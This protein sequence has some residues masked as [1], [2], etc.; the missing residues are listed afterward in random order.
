MRISEIKEKVFAFLNKKKNIRIQGISGT[1]LSY[2]Y[3]E[4]LKD[5]NKTNLIILPNKKEA[6]KVLK[7]FLFFV[8]NKNIYEFAPYDISPFSGLSPHKE[9]I[10]KRMGSLYALLNEKAPIIVTSIDAI[11]LKT[12][13]KKDFV[14]FIDYVEEGEELDR[15]LF[16]KKLEEGGYQRVP[17]VEDIGD[18]AVRGS[19]IDIFPPLYQNPIRLEFWGDLVESI[20]QF[21]P[22]TQRSLSNKK[23]AIILPCSEIILN[24]R[25]LKRA[26]SLGRLPFSDETNPQFSGKEAW[27][28]H[29]YEKPSSIFEYLPKDAVITIYSYHSVRSVSQRIKE[30]FLKDTERFKKEAAERGDPFP[31]V[32]GLTLK[33]EELMYNISNFQTIQLESSGPFDEKTETVDV[34]GYFELTEDIE[35]RIPEKG[36]VSLAPLAEK[37]EEWKEH[38][39]RVVIVTRTKEQAE[40]LKEILKNY[41]VTV[42]R[43]LNSWKEVP[44]N[45]SGIFICLGNIANGFVWQEIGLYVISEDQIFGKKKET[46]KKTSVKLARWA[47][48]GQFKEGDL[49]VHEEHGIG[50]Y[51]GLK[52]IEVNNKINEYA[53]IEYAENSKL[54]IPADR[55]SILQKYIGVEGKEPK[56]DQLGGRSWDIAKR[57]AKNS[58]KKIAKHLVE[59]Y[60]I[61]QTRKG[62]AFSPP[63]HMFREF[64]ATF[65]HEETPDQIKAIED[66]LN[67]MTSEKPMDRLICGDVGFGKTEVAIRAAF[68]AVMDGKQVAII[69]PTTL[70]AEQHYRTFKN[71]MSPYH[72]RVEILSRFRSKTEQAKIIAELRSG[73]IDIIIGTHRLLQKDIK[74]SD[75]GLLIIDEEQKFGVK[76]KELLKK[77]RTTVDVLSLAATPIPRTL[78]MALLGVKDISIIETPPQDRLSIRTHISYYDENLIAKAIRFELKRKGQVFFVHNRVQTI[79][80]VAEKIKKLVPE[81]KLAVAHGQMKESELEKTMLS[82][83]NKEI[84]VLVCTSI[85]ESGLDIPSVNTIIID[86]VEK[87]GLAQIY[88]LRGRVGR[89]KE[90]AYAYLLISDP[91]SITPEGEK[92]LKALM[93]FSRLGAGLQLAM[94]DLKIR[95]G[96]NILGYAQSGHIAEI[97]YELYVKLIEQTIA[98]LKGEEWHEDINPEI[99]ISIPAYI[100][101]TY[102]M[103][104][105]LRLNIYR[106]LSMLS[107]ESELLK[108][109]EELLDRFGDMPEEV[110]NLFD[111]MSIRIILKKAKIS[112]LD[113]NTDG[114]TLTFGNNGY[115]DTE[116]IVKLVTQK[117]ALFK[118]ISQNKIKINTKNLSLTNNLSK[119]RS[120]LKD[121]ASFITPVSV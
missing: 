28:T 101:E 64:E 121:I 3:S 85:I 68:K 108:V 112:K 105:D 81:A 94:H 43:L 69:V 53:I 99:N 86:G 48:I 100:P 89:S 46:K 29:F 87:M 78:H 18:Y 117:P 19:V 72:I 37:V 115:I 6:N 35:I 62:F 83:L 71:R 36:R 32:E 119:I 4:L 47:D 39:G 30:K 7:E 41:S 88:Q 13:P 118:F 56:L 50:R 61:R 54:Y 9:I 24:E 102:I 17:I 74:F 34:P 55:I 58:I 109:K 20:R 2:L 5:L 76:Q 82:F 26:R 75:L 106:R 10:S 52:K 98:E 103:D 120:I 38:G 15:D 31:E 97:G 59:L 73:K 110:K 67:D 23:S 33:A 8:E 12:I 27:L 1:A 113:V 116:R 40:R 114:I 21:D 57:R 65:E 66:V 111:I 22:F 49:V 91:S 92:R 51:M 70:L 84:D 11:F 25:S 45:S 63:D 96:G 42:D 60:A 80:D 16:I 44:G 90:K 77:Y 79:Y 107:E 93:D 95:G 14:E 104:N